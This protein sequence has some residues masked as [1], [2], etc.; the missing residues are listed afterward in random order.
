[1]LKHQFDIAPLSILIFLT[2]SCL[3]AGQ[4]INPGPC[5]KDINY[6]CVDSTRLA[7]TWYIQ[8]SYPVWMDKDYRCQQTGFTRGHIVSSDISNVD[9]SE[10]L[11]TGTLT[12]LEDG[13]LQIKYNGEDALFFKVLSVDYNN[14]IVMYSCLDLSS[15]NHAEYVFIHTREPKFDQEVYELYTGALKTQ[16]I[17]TKELK[18]TNQENCENFA[19]QPSKRH[20]WC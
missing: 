11:K 6:L 1:M 9:G 17:S 4:V 2:S 5:R 8:Y 3:V 7:G 15:G 16:G 18:W 19:E 14:Y 12:F 20:R 13:Q 10:R